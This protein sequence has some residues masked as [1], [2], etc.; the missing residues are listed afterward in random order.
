MSSKIAIL[1]AMLALT[2]TVVHCAPTTSP[3]QSPMSLMPLQLTTSPTQAPVLISS[4]SSSSL[5]LATTSILS[6]TSAPTTNKEHNTSAGY[7][8]PQLIPTYLIVVIAAVAFI[9]LCVAVVCSVRVRTRTPSLHQPPLKVN[10]TFD[11]YR[12]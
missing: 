8:A 2:A 5:Q 6:P 1:F 12:Y 4:T 11:P 9:T 7:D 3:T 10:R